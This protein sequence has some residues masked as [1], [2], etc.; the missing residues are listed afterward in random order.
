MTP[1]YTGQRF[2]V[3]LICPDNMKQLPF[4]ASE[5]WA[6]QMFRGE[7]QF[8]DLRSKFEIT[9]LCTGSM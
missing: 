3:R 1:Q 8:Q 2:H 9:L 5:Q 7:D 4:I 6:D